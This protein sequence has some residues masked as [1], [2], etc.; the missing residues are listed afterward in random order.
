MKKIASILLLFLLLFLEVLSQKDSTK[1]KIV[2]KKESIK[3]CQLILQDTSFLKKIDSLSQTTAYPLNFTTEES[4]VIY[5][6]IFT[7][8]QNLYSIHVYKQNRFT[9]IKGI[10]GV[11]KLGE[12][13][14]C[15]KEKTF[16]NFLNVQINQNHS[17]TKHILDIK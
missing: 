12:I 7:C 9:Y 1:D 13:Y 4:K 5:L 8:G 16:P 15:L 11:L 6:D 17:I 10:W 3:L 14:L 2:T